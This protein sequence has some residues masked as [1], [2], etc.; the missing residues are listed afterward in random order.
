MKHIQIRPAGG[1]WVIRAAGA[2]LA[3]SKNAL[4]LIEGDYKPVIYF[5]RGDIAM[6]FLDTSD[7][8]THC[9]HKGKASYYNIVTKNQPIP[10]AGWSYDSPNDDAADIAGHIAFYADKVTVEQV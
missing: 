8:T 5:P 9:T 4:E 1:T 3:E 10:D 2:V 6:A 7:T